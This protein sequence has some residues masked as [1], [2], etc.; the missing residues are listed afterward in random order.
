MICP[1]FA[2]LWA[3]DAWYEPPDGG[4]YICFHL[5][6]NEERKPPTCAAPTVKSWRDKFHFCYPSSQKRRRALD[7]PFNCR[8]G[9]WFGRLLTS[10]FAPT[11]GPSDFLHCFKLCSKCLPQVQTAPSWLG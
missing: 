4:S 8:S 6:K 2:G 1:V 10:E 9:R 3:V 5:T 11:K 7:S